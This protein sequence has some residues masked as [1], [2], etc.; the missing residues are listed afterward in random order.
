MVLGCDE[1]PKI[2]GVEIVVE[3]VDVRVVMVVEEEDD[4]EKRGWRDSWPSLLYRN[5]T[6]FSRVN[7]GWL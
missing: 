4:D 7:S 1:E 6:K 2:P 3:T 5:W